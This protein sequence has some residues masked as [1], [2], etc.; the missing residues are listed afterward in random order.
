MA[1]I[2]SELTKAVKHRGSMT[3]GVN[4]LYYK[5]FK[6]EFK[7]KDDVIARFDKDI[8]E[9]YVKGSMT[10][11]RLSRYNNLCNGF[12]DYKVFVLPEGDKLRAKSAK[13]GAELL[14]PT[15]G[16][17]YILPTGEISVEPFEI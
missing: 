10:P 17:L 1:S 4:K 15:G 13:T 3:R 6:H 7:V 9:L 5:D 2:T 14:I 8:M 11:A 12:T 16:K